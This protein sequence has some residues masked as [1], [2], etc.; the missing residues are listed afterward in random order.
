MQTIVLRFKLSLLCMSVMILPAGAQTVQVD[1]L[2]PNMVMCLNNSTGNSVV[3]SGAA[4]AD[5]RQLPKNE[6]DALSIIISGTSGM[7]PPGPPSCIP[8]DEV[9]QADPN[10][11]EG[12]GTLMPNGCL[13]FRGEIS[14]A[15]NP[16]S[17]FNS[18]TDEDLFV[19][20]S[21]NVSTVNLS[22]TSSIAAG[23]LGV[24]LVDSAGAIIDCTN[25]PTN[26]QTMVPSQFGL[27]LVA[28]DVGNYTV[29]IKDASTALRKNELDKAE[30][31]EQLP[32]GH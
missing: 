27:Y 7:P 19:V 21:P 22:F 14:G 5:C 32:F 29:Q 18:G 4:V 17:S 3:L 10:Q 9:E 11:I 28:L 24:L 12:S 1:G 16:D 25:T 6:G 23:R 20:E 13:E 2:T 8:I 31:L 30:I 15:L 26:C